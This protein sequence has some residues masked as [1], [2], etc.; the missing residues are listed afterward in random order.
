VAAGS[1][2]G[3]ATAVN[4]ASSGKRDVATKSIM[5]PVLRQHGLTELIIK[6]RLAAAPPELIKS[7][8]F[9]V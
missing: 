5:A 1:V 7:V 2:A 3:C 8:F 4:P 6:K 9:E